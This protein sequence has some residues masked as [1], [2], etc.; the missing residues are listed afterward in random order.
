MFQNFTE[1]NEKV[2]IL[3]FL[4]YVTYDKVF[5]FSLVILFFLISEGALTG[6]MRFLAYY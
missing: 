1:K 4:K 6:F 5:L 3:L 2:T